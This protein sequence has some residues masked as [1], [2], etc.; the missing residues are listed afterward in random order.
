MNCFN[1]WSWQ[2]WLLSVVKVKREDVCS[3]FFFIGLTHFVV[4]RRLCWAFSVSSWHGLKT[5]Q[6]RHPSSKRDNDFV[7]S[8]TTI[9]LLHIFRRFQLVRR[10]FSKL[11]TVFCGSKPCSEKIAPRSKL[12]ITFR[13]YFFQEQDW[14]RCGMEKLVPRFLPLCV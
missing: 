6:I 8:V 13:C 12:S 7:L 9:L 14:V 5:F 1:F 4:R 2:H 10:C 11:S 3:F